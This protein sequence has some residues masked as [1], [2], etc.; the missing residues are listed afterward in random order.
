M[1]TGIAHP[2]WRAF[3]RP[4]SVARHRLSPATERG[5]RPS[6]ARPRT[7][8]PDR[9]LPNPGNDLR[10]IGYTRVSTEEQASEGVSLAAQS[11]RIAAWCEGQG[12]GPDEVRIFT[13][14]GIS[15]KRADNRPG[16]Q[17][18]L[19]AACAGPC[20]L[21][22][23][24]L[25]RVARSVRDTLDIADRLERAGADLVS[26]SEQ[27]DTTTAAGKMLFRLMAV[28]AE[29]ERDLTVE[30]T[31]GA[32]AH[33]RA[34]GERTGSV[35]RGF[36]VEDDGRR[37]KGG[38]PVALVEDPQELADLVTIAAL[39]RTGLGARPIARMMAETGRPWPESTVRR[40]LKRGPHVPR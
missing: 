10:A 4:R 36:R 23:Y 9:P 16:L 39:A 21:V 1:P 14:E 26:L 20:A 38:K 40:I 24:S 19:D 34:R 27:L 30:R 33:K 17:A 28:L 12:I 5:R 2:P 15:G 11:A 25:S 6:P 13:D 8:A 29:F 37:S 35:P 18:A 32:L 22:V 7:V 31:R 3:R